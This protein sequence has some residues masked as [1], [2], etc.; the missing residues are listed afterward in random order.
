MVLKP[1][2]QFA[3]ITLSLIV[4]LIGPGQPTWAQETIPKEPRASLEAVLIHVNQVACNETTP[5]LGRKDYIMGK[6][7]VPD[8]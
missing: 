6:L 8:L 7:V 1:K 3:V 5:M 4:S 2:T